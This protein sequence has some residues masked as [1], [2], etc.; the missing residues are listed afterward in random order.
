MINVYPSAIQVPA[1]PSNFRACFPK[2]ATFS[3]IVCH[4]TSGHDD[5]N[6][7]AQ[8]FAAKKDKPSSA[9]FVV[10][11]KP[12]VDEPIIQCVDLGDVAYHASQVNSTSV[13]I[14]HVGREPGEFGKNDLGLP[15][16][17]EQYAKSA[18]LCAWLC[19]VAGIPVDDQHIVGHAECSPRDGHDKCPTG[20][21]GGWDWDR[22]IELV[23]TAY[24][25]LP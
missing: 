1:H 18:R 15:I 16:T 12:E 2:R 3:L 17:E 21:A 9:H 23:K 25:A 8:M 20:V 10:G 5:P 11:R 7:T 22:Y 4:V 13:G 19:R 6:G 14:E 24:V